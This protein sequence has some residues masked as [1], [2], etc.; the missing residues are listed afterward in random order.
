M[1]LNLILFILLLT[2]LVNGVERPCKCKQVY[3]FEKQSIISP[4]QDKQV[5]DTRDL[6]DFNCVDECSQLIRKN[7]GGN[8][9]FLTQI[10]LEKICADVSSQK[11]VFK[12][13]ISLINNWELLD[14]TKNEL[15]L[16]DNLCC[17]MCKCRFSFLEQ[18]TKS[19]LQAE[20]I[21]DELTA[22][23]FKKYGEKRAYECSQLDHHKDCEIDCRFEI[24][25]LIGGYD[26][27]NDLAV[28]SYNT[29]DALASN[30]TYSNN[31]CKILNKRVYSPGLDLVARIE[32][33]PRGI[34]WHKDVSLGN[35][36]CKRVCTCEIVYKHTNRTLNKI[37]HVIDL[38]DK[39]P[40]RPLSYKCD[41]ELSECVNDCKLAAGIHLKSV[42]LQDERVSA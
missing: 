19:E 4:S 42:E 30:R 16:K 14:C 15:V 21:I 27:I 41:E 1:N 25:K 38:A 20:V 24:A 3:K 35:I 36:C 18:I 17:R 32:T 9:T 23:I 10:G 34:S 39:L 33:G 40:Q 7:I 28:D 13:G 37:E 8:E 12:D 29:L 31:I 5:P 6:C 22:N 11:S 26:K 2:S